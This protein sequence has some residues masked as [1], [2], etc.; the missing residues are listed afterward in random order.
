MYGFYIASLLTFSHQEAAQFCF[1]ML[2][3]ECEICD[4][5]TMNWHGKELI[6][7]QISVLES[8]HEQCRLCN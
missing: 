8:L 6:Q 5:T 7:I 3:R 1:N 2:E 4:T